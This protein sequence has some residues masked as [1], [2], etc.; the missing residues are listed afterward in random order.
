VPYLR[1]SRR[2]ERAD[3]IV[4]TASHMS[5]RGSHLDVSA[6]LADGII[7][8]LPGA[9]EEPT[10]IPADRRREPEARLSA[11]RGGLGLN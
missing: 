3:Q 9:G 7:T 8:A 4:G 1:R 10:V 11:S 5:Y 2:A 6:A